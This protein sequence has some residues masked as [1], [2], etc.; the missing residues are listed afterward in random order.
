VRGAVLS[1]AHSLAE[2]LGESFPLSG[3]ELEDLAGR[4][5]F[6]ETVNRIAVELDLPVLRK[7]HLL[8]EAVPER[9]LSLLAILRGRRQVVDLLSPYRHLAGKS[10]LN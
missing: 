7:L 10:D 2:D 9:A 6:E 8:T 3:E 4:C 1:L 5:G